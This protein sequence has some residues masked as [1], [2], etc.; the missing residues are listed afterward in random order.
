[1][2]KEDFNP[3]TAFNRSVITTP[4]FTPK[5]VEEIRE[6]AM[7]EV[8][9]RNN[10]NFLK[11][12]IDKAIHDFKSVVDNYPHFDFANFYLGEAY[13]KKGNRE[14]AIEYY[15]KTLK[16]RP[17]HQDAKARLEELARGLAA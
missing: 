4:E 8:C 6:E 9:F 17:D 16:I 12:D 2:K 14:S 1:M 13:L 15:E 10:A 7:I 11:Y 5:E 3:I